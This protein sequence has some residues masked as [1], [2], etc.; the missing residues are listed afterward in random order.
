MHKVSYKLSVG[1]WAINSADDPRT[2]FIELDISCSMDSPADC[3]RVAVYA[4]P[5][6]PPGLL[7]QAIGAAVGALG[8]GAGGEEP[9]SV[10]IR[11][12]AIKHGDQLTIELSAG[13]RSGKV[14]TAEVQAIESSFGQTR[15]TSHT[16]KQRL[17][18][19]RLNQVYENQ[20]LNQITKD[21][22]GQAGVNT[23]T[24]ETGSSYSYVVVDESVSLLKTVREL[25]RRDG[26]DLYFDSD[27]KLTLKKFDK[28]SADH[29]FFYG[30][31]ILDLRLNN[32]RTTS[33]HILVYGESP[34]SNQG[35]DAWHWL[36]KDLSPFRSEIGEGVK[37]RAIGDGALRTKDAAANLATAKFGALKDQM[38]QGRLKILGHPQVKLGDAIEI[39]NVPKPEL[40]GLFKVASVRH[41][42]NKRDGYLTFVG[43]S[44]LGG[45]SAAAGM[46]GELA[47]QLGGALGL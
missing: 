22:A 30:I 45:A 18:N 15:I 14:V 6:L 43:F 35:S 4:P 20:T 9:F 40:N 3:C 17:A 36:A 42:L 19:A 32:H 34:A 33:D 1:G 25:A 24:I 37:R 41:V 21:L 10:Q 31:D 46:L 38:V 13:D 16:G 44:G 29:T 47:G 39:K 23:G 12:N 11:G 8:L 28:T 2:E 27:D 7:D 26:L 5:A